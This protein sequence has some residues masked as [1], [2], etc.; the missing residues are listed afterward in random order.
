[1]LFH[2]THIHNWENCPAHYPEKAKASFGKLLANEEGSEAKIICAYVD[3]P[4]HTFYLIV[5]AN[6]AKQLE[7]LLDPVFE[8]GSAEIRPIS[9]ALE[10]LNRRTN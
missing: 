7:L 1:M 10:V 5:E 3:P 4:A 9:D 6:D 2:I 8:L